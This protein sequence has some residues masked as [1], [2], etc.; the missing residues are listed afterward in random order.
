MDELDGKLRII[1]GE[2]ATNGVG[3]NVVITANTFDYPSDVGDDPFYAIYAIVYDEIEITYNVITGWVHG[4]TAE[5]TP[6]KLSLLAFFSV[7]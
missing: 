3:K 1:S 5:P 2:D 6:V 7:E 4:S